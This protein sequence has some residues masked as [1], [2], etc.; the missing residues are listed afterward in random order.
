MSEFESKAIE[1]LRTLADAARK[2]WEGDNAEDY[3]EV[4]L[5]RAEDFLKEVVGDADIRV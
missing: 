4:E 3:F 5:V 1:H 2:F